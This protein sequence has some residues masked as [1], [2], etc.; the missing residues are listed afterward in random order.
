MTTDQPITRPTV[1]LDPTV[2]PDP[3]SHWGQGYAIVSPQQI[4]TYAGHRRAAGEPFA[5][6]WVYPF[7]GEAN[8]HHALA[9]LA[10][11]E[12]DHRAVGS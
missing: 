3:M 11:I 12:A 8:A 5:G 1:L 9:R 2:L 4:P 7:P 10:Q 6:M